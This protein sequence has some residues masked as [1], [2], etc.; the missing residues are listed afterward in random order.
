MKKLFI[1]M[2]TILTCGA[3]YALPVGNPSDASLLCDGLLWEGHCGD[4]CDPCLSCVDALSF[5]TGFYGD[6]VFNR[7][8]EIDRSADDSDIESTRIF[9]NAAFLAANLWDRIDLF[10][11]LGTT[12]IS[13]STN[14]VS[15]G[16]SNGE[17]LRVETDSHFSWSLG[18]RGTI[19]ECGCTTFGMEA[20]Y[21]QTRP[22]VRRITEAASASVYPD[23]SIKTK[24]HEWQVGA[25]ISHRI[26]MFVPYIAVKWS[27]ARLNFKDEVAGAPLASS[28]FDLK[29][30]KQWG[31]ALGVSLIDCEKASVTAEG[32]FGDEKALYING[33]IRF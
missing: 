19:W 26:N 4:P 11:T 5:R 1:T 8:L 21:F 14:A 31:Y 23:S 6:Y 7:H 17:R 32:R 15:F 25:G 24:Y 33:Q 28:L 12:N 18:L 29:N 9:T 27:R 10:S 30:G 16:G 20:Q 2:L 13:L 22:N 3:A